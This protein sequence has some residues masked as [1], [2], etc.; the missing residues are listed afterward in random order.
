MKTIT[1]RSLISGMKVNA[2]YNDTNQGDDDYE[3]LGFTGDKY[4]YGEDEFGNTAEI[5]FKS[6]KELLKHYNVKSFKALEELQDKN[7]YGFRSHMV[8]RDLKTDK[9]GAWFYLHHGRWSRGSGAEPL[10]FTL[11]EEF[12]KPIEVK[13]YIVIKSHTR[14]GDKEIS[15]TLE[16][17]IKYFGYTL[18][19]GNSHKS[20][21]N[22]NPKTIK[23]FISNINKA[24]NV[25]EGACYERTYIE[26]K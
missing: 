14:R 9:I 25:V 21:I 19:I 22:R 15:G 7:E 2:A 18:E 24:F 5:K 20:N 26:L 11:L 4:K 13:S 12:E 3:F 23:S 17:L 10:S 16:E 1:S 6:S 8:V